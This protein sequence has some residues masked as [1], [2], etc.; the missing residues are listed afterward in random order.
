MKPETKAQEPSL[1]IEEMNKAIAEF[2][3][4]KWKAFREDVKPSYNVSYDKL[5]N[6]EQECQEFCNLINQPNAENTEMWYIPKPEQINLTYHSDWNELKRVLKK[7][8]EVFKE[9]DICKTPNLRN[10]HRDFDTSWK[11]WNERLG[12]IYSASAQFDIF[13]AHLIAYECIQWY[14]QQLKQ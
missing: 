8:H 6:S 14:N 13:K 3:G 2:E 12:W 11:P 7:L 4:L 9:H 5:F 10:Y 1:T